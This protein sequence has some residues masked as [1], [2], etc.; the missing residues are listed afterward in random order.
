MKI[1][2][3]LDT[4]LEQ[5][6]KIEKQSED[7]WSYNILKQDFSEDS[8]SEYYVIKEDG[9]ILGFVSFMNILG[10]VHVN[11]IAVDTGKRRRGL[12]ARLL[13]FVLNF[14]PKEEIM[15]V[16][17]EVRTDNIPALKLYEK[18]GFSIVGKRERYY[19]RNKDAFIMWKMLGDIE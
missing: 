8:P 15:G 16:T 2:K 7:S 11:N 3:A 17:L 13:K 12:G 18:F 19:K 10:E 14:Y 1:E 4:D 9:E 5:I 6:Y